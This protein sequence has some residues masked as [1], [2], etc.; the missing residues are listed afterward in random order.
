[1]HDQL[2]M[3][4]LGIKLEVIY[5]C[6]CVCV[7]VPI[8]VCVCVLCNIHTIR[9][10]LFAYLRFLTSSWLRTEKQE[11]PQEHDSAG[12]TPTLRAL[13]SHKQAQV[14]K[15]CQSREETGNSLRLGLFTLQHF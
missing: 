12:A 10:G 7:C 1:M 4:D 5:V 15:I 8:S 9:F 3:S 2:T 13:T 11:A 14:W 6:V